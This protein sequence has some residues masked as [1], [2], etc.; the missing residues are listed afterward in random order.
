MGAGSLDVGRNV[1]LCLLG[2]PTLGAPPRLSACRGRSAGL[3]SCD[4]PGPAAT[5]ST[6]GV[7]TNKQNSQT[8]NPQESRKEGEWETELPGLPPTPPGR[9]RKPAGQGASTAEPPAGASSPG[10]TL[11]GDSGERGWPAGRAARRGWWVR[12]GAVPGP[13]GWREAA[14]PPGFFH[15]GGKS[16]GELRKMLFSA[17]R[18]RG[19]QR[20]VL[21]A[22]RAIP[23]QRGFPGSTLCGATGERDRCAVQPGPKHNKRLGPWVAVLVPRHGAPACRRSPAAGESLRPGRGATRE[24]P[25]FL[26]QGAARSLKNN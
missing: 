13:P 3:A 12:A 11:P 15:F 6:T 16:N 17:L 23:P 18:L 26:T 5:A 21:P 9:D 7:K 1:L 25:K 24:R 4:P 2:K 19:C 8:T 20:C 14:S 22:E 10:K